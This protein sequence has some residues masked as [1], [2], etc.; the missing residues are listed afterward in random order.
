M[1]LIPRNLESHQ[2]SNHA[3]M[4]HVKL[5]EVESQRLSFYCYLQ[6][7]QLEGNQTVKGKNINFIAASAKRRKNKSAARK[8]E[9]KVC[10]RR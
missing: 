4:E 10:D 1:A 3:H 7:F 2:H 8:Y 9:Q 6:Q 5:L